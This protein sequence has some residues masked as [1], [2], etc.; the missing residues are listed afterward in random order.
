MKILTTLLLLTALFLSCQAQK[1]D[2]LIY[3]NT[4]KLDSCIEIIEDLRAFIVIQNE[5]LTGNE[6]TVRADTYNFEIADDKIKVELNKIGHEVFISVLRE[7][8]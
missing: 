1:P 2:T 6:M 4:E 5:A 3:Y 7:E 8:D